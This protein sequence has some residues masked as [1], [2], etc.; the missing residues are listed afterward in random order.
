MYRLPSR[1]VDAV[2]AVICLVAFPALSDEKG[3]LPYKSAGAFAYAEKWCK[4]G[5]DC[6][7]GQ[8]LDPNNTDCTHFM[9]HV[10]KAGGVTVPGVGAKCDRGL[11][12]RVR[13]LAV[14]FSDGTK[15]YSNIK[16]LKSWREAKRGDF[17]F[18]QST[19][20]GLNLGRK[21]HVMLLADSPKST[22]AKVCGHQHN[23][24]G[25]FTEFDVDDCVYYRIEE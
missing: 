25:E 21:Y 15:K 22:G 14:W 7:S 8:Y 2:L 9:S 4:E 24:C 1:N 20:L 13:E 12:I 3:K 11:C 6:P 17:C 5:N 23:R 10:L 16:K 18:L 19:I